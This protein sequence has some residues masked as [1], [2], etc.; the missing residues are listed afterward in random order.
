[1]ADQRDVVEALDDAAI[2]QTVQPVEQVGGHRGQ[3]GNSVD[4][5]HRLRPHGPIDHRHVGR[6]RRLRQSCFIII[7]MFYLFFLLLL[8]Q[9]LSLSNIRKQSGL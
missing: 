7:I 4:V 5:I 9:L 8:L 6:V 2:T 1:V 3:L